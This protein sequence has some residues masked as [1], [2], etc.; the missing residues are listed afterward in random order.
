MVSSLTNIK[1]DIAGL[2]YTINETHTILQNLTCSNSL[3]SSNFLQETLIC[4]EIFP[5]TSNGE[6]INLEKN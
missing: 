6:L 5:N 4:G 3:N 1:Y 2:T